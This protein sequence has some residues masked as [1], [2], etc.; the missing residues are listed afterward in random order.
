V[1]TARHRGIP[2]FKTD[3]WRVSNEFPDSDIVQIIRD[4]MVDEM[5][6]SGEEGEDPGMVSEHNTDS[7]GGSS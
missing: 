1:Q 3:E 5:V 6:D 4:E 2:T 7:R